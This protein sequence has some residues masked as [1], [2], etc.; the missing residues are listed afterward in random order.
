MTPTRSLH[1]GSRTVG[2][3]ARRYPNELLE[4]ALA[5]SVGDKVEARLPPR[6]HARQAPRAHA[7][8]GI[9]LQQGIDW[10][11]AVTISDKNRKRFEGI[12][13]EY[14]RREL[15]VGNHQY[16]PID[17][18]TQAEAR[19][20]VVEQEDKI[21]KTEAQRTCREKVIMVAAIV[22]AIAAIIVPVILPLIHWQ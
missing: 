22:A 8:L 11:V 3:S 12:G 5:H 6:R 16:I 7:R 2:Q 19:E 18:P 9:V 4:L 10:S 20:W 21:R 14:I 13:L 1:P 17:A 15:T